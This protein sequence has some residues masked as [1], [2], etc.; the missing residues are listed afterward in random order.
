MIEFPVK[1]CTIEETTAIGAFL[2]AAVAL[3]WFEGLAAAYDSLFSGGGGQI[4]A[5]DR[6]RAALYRRQ[7]KARRALAA[8]L[9]HRQ[10]SLALR[11]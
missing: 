5:P 8:A 6:D 10:I 9:D 7:G 4:F 1:R 11:G 3:G 2:A